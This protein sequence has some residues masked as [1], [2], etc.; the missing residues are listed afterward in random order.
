MDIDSIWSEFIYAFIDRDVAKH[1][2]SNQTGNLAH[3][4][5]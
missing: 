1:L 3:L 5:I 2:Q 4:L